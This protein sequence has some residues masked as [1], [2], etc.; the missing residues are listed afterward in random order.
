MEGYRKNLEIINNILEDSG[1]VRYNAIKNRFKN[2]SIDSP[3]LLYF[4]KSTIP[5]DNENTTAIGTYRT[6]LQK[7]RRKIEERRVRVIEKQVGEMVTR[8]VQ[9]KNTVKKQETVV[10]VS[11]NGTV[12]PYEVKQP[13]IKNTK[14]DLLSTLD[15]FKHANVFG[16][17][18]VLKNKKKH[19]ANLRLEENILATE[20]TDRKKGTKTTVVTDITLSKVYLIFKNQKA[21]ISC[22]T[23]PSHRV[24]LEK[25]IEIVN[26]NAAGEKMAEVIL[27]N[28][29]TG[30]FTKHCTASLIFSVEDVHKETVEYEIETPEEFIRWIL[31]IKTRMHTV[32]RWS[33]D[34]LLDLIRR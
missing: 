6:N 22:L 34:E 15:D 20:I 26:V 24:C 21:F 18:T 19:S 33:K 25:E 3:T 29:N 1:I 10:T 17:A 2:E 13:G 11:P 8:E 16:S 12:T 4:Y 32:D 23:K 27:K 7:L 5:K 28:T 31:L 14:I 30:G 9:E